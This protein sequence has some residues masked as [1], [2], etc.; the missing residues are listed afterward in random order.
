MKHQQE[1]DDEGYAFGDTRMVAHE[2]GLPEPEHGIWQRLPGFMDAWRAAT[3]VYNSPGPLEMTAHGNGVQ[4]EIGKR[5][6][7]AARA[8]FEARW[9]V[10]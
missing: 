9:R 1:Y 3:A 4:D 2:M 8:V 7:A 5:A 6:K 10:Y